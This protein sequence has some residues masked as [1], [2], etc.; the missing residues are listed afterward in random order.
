MSYLVRADVGGRGVVRPM[1]GLVRDAMDWPFAAGER[2]L[3]LHALGEVQAVVIDFHGEATSEKMAMGHFADGRASM[4]VGTH[5]HVPTADAQIL[6]RGTASQTGCGMC[7][8]CD[9]GI[10][11]QKQRAGS[12]FGT[13]R[14]DERL[15]AADAARTP[16]ARLVDT[17]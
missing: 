13:H 6:T 1:G 3:G 5:S 11:M 16:C 15:R 10:G 9:S 7:G 14:P 12:R 4:V 8:D 2:E 17:E